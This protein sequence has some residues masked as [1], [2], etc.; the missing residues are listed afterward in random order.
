MYL[1]EFSKRGVKSTDKDLKCVGV[2]IAI[3][4]IVVIV[5]VIVIVVVV[6]VIVGSLSMELPHVVSK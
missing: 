6:I 1:A 3:V 5:V 4:L 2:V